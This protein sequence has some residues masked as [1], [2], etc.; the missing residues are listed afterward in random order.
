VRHSLVQLT[1][2]VPND[3]TL[4]H[5]AALYKLLAGRVIFYAAQGGSTFETLAGSKATA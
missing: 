5:W 2:N 1:L 4:L 3:D